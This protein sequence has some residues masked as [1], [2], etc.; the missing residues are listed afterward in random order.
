LLPKLT[1]PTLLLDAEKCRNNIRRMQLKA[2]RQKIVFRP[3]FKTH[4]SATIARWFAGGGTNK[5]TVSSVS[6]ARY[7][8]SHGWNDIMVAF[9]LNLAELHQ[10]IKLSTEISLSV[11]VENIEAIRALASSNIRAIN[12]Y[13]K[14]DAGYHRTG[15]P[16]KN[17]GQAQQLIDTIDEQ[18]SL[19]F[20]G[21]VVHNGHTYHVRSPQEVR[22]IH[23]RSVE[24]L[25]KLRQAVRSKSG[26]VLISV[27]DTPSMSIVDDL[28]GVD[29]IRPG[30][31][32]FY[33]VMQQQIGACTYDDIAVALACP[34]VALHKQRNEIIIYGGAIHLSKESI[35]DTDGTPIYGKIVSLTGDGWSSPW[36]DSYVK[37]LSQEHGIVRTN[38][39]ILNQ[40]CVGDFIGIL[41]IH[42]CLTSH[43][44]QEMISTA[45]QAIATMQSPK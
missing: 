42:S 45:G 21:F 2:N 44:M 40:I 19:H 23:H 6:M 18:P 1:R 34:V 13:L 3:H 4:Q 33:D 30:N 41:P 5:I 38:P 20:R 32:V 15:V 7:F 12:V 16:V 31:F 27:G 22:E 26:E 29:E 28:T 9:P 8:A 17:H 35:N 10:F 25:H 11:V 36:P 24:A 37:S 14:I 39:E 43:L